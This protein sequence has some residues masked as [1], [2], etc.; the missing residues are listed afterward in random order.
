VHKGAIGAVDKHIAHPGDPG[1]AHL[2]FVYWQQTAGAF[3]EKDV[4]RTTTSAR[5]QAAWSGGAHA[6]LDP[7]MAELAQ[8]KTTSG[9]VPAN[10]IS[11][12]FVTADTCKKIIRLNPE[13]SNLQ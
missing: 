12:D 2:H 6:N 1:T 10:V 3:G 7:F 4:F 5:G 9:K 11:H 13:C 8:K